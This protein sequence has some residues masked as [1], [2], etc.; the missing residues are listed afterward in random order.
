MTELND[1]ISRVMAEA[2]AMPVNANVMDYLDVPPRRA[3]F[4]YGPC[5]WSGNCQKGKHIFQA[6]SN[7]PYLLVI[8]RSHGGVW[9]R[10]RSL[11]MV[12]KASD[13]TILFSQEKGDSTISI[14][15]NNEKIGEI[16]GGRRRYGKII[17]SE[18]L[19]CEY[20]V[21]FWMPK[22]VEYHF[23]DGP[24]VKGGYC[25]NGSAAFVIPE[26]SGLVK[27]MQPQ[28]I[29]LFIGVNAWY[30]TSWCAPGE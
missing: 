27:S 19:W 29:Q 23:A 25:S 9:T 15:Q 6:E 28:D 13:W 2:D 17:R 7:A 11:A 3:R 14:T 12:V 10:P 18:K 21:R 26:D 8:W 20:S 30:Q 16:P 5:S 22:W 1:I 4:S 24:T